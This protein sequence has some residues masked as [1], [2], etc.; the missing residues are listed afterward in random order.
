MMNDDLE[1]R[2]YLESV[3]EDD[4]Q[5]YYV[6]LET[7]EAI[8]ET[9]MLKKPVKKVDADYLLTSNT[10]M[11][12][13]GQQLFDFVNV[14]NMEEGTV[15]LHNGNKNYIFNLYFGKNVFETDLEFKERN[16]GFFVFLK[17]HRG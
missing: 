5:Y 16:N 7:K 3:F 11:G 9:E 1:Y 17:K 10:V 12:P 4:W 13:T 15:L 8:P 14:I 6:N 2:K